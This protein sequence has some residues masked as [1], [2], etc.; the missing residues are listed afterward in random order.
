MRAHGVLGDAIEDLDAQ[1]LLDP[2][3]E[4][5]NLPAAAVQFGDAERG[6]REVVGEEDEV[7]LGVGVIV[8]YTPQLLG[9]GGAGIMIFS[10][11]LKHQ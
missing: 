6:Q 7:L 5:F 3:E 11:A 2:L 9:I 4:Q 10:A 8:A 1:M